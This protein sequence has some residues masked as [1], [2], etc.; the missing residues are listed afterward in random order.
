MTDVTY[1]L[2]GL[3]FYYYIRYGYSRAWNAQTKRPMYGPLLLPKRYI[4]CL[5]LTLLLPILRGLQVGLD[6]WS[7]DSLLLTLSLTILH[8][9]R[10]RAGP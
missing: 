4:Y 1:L 6:R 10:S 9:L 3:Y 5:L 2:L 8:G 7:T